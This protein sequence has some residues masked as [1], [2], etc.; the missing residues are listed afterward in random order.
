[1]RLVKYYALQRIGEYKES[2]C[3]STIK[4][5]DYKDATDLIVIIDD[6]KR[7]EGEKDGGTG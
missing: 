2:D 6:G 7:D 4:L 5:R 3:A 1:M